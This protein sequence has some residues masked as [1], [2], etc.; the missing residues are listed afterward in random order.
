MK[1]IG[2][3]TL[4]F[5]LLLG[6]VSK[7]DA[8]IILEQFDDW[9]VGC[10]KLDKSEKKELDKII[11]LLEKDQVKDR[12]NGLLDSKEQLETE[13]K[14]VEKAVCYESI[15]KN[16]EAIGA[17]NLYYSL[18]TYAQ[19]IDKKNSGEFKELS[20]ELGG[21]D[22]HQL[23]AVLDKSEKKIHIDHFYSSWSGNAFLDFERREVEAGLKKFEDNTS[24]VAQLTLD[25]A[26]RIYRVIQTPIDK[27]L[28]IILSYLEG[29]AEKERKFFRK[30][31]SLPTISFRFEL[32]LIEVDAGT[33]DQELMKQ[34]YP[35][36][37]SLT[38]LKRWEAVTHILPTLGYPKAAIEK[39]N[40]NEVAEE[41]ME[42]R[43][44]FKIEEFDLYE[45][46]L[47]GEGSYL[48]DEEREELIRKVD[49]IEK[50]MQ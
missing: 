32:S 28:S 44:D 18:L 27:A 21:N 12:M 2:L 9:I 20:I 39:E 45:F 33:K 11:E 6:P 36:R 46:V 43:S 35:T 40:W 13:T 49:N 30:D 10:A 37:K 16:P 4:L 22:I 23:D 31:A 15:E 41:L 38:I 48:T 17:F 3:F 7:A 50:V 26:D 24:I 19:K 14:L 47:G 42:Y 25:V 29:E 34:Y 8:A 1:K 5:I